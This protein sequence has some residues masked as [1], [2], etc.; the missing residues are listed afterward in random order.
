[1]ARLVLL[2]KSLSCSSFSLSSLVLGL[3]WRKYS[4]RLGLAS[5]H[6]RPL[7]I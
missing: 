1:M 5:R 7:F 2:L 3:K 4:T 6:W